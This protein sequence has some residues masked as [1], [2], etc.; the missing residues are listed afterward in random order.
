MA[1]DIS[2][3]LYVLLSA[4][5]KHNFRDGAPAD[6]SYGGKTTA[7]QGQLISDTA[8]VAD[9]VHRAAQSYGAKKA[10]RTMGLKFPG[11]TVPSLQEFTEAAQ[12]LGIA[13]IRLTPVR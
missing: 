6:V 13:V 1:H 7:M 8:A 3:D 5:W 4:G 2:G 10:Q 12:R 11:D 9:L